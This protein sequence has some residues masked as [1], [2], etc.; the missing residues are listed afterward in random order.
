VFFQFWITCCC[1]TLLY[2]SQDALLYMQHASDELCYFVPKPDIWN[3]EEVYI[4]TSDNEKIHGYFYKVK[5]AIVRTVPTVLFLHGNAGSIG[6]PAYL[7]VSLQTPVNVLA[8]DYRGYGKSSG[9]P[10]ENGLYFDADAALQYLIE[11]N[12]I[13][14]SKIVVYGHS[15]GGAVAIHIATI[16]HPDNVAAVIVENSFTSI[17]ETACSMFSCLSLLLRF[18]PELCFKN[19][20][21][22]L[23]KVKYLKK[24]ILFVCGADDKLLPPK[25]TSDLYEAC[26]SMDKRMKICANHGHN[27]TL[28]SLACIQSISCF[29][30]DYFDCKISQSYQLPVS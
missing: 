28:F 4:T 9:K 21:N 8:I 25:M 23:S 11:C 3:P 27:D 1:L 5:D 6:F 10:S 17:R 30:H 15:L 19:K 20:F 29:L 13:D 16:S 24:P 2:T 7:L 12:E 18:L 14:V 26:A 22:S